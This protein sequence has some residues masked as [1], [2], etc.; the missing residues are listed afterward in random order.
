M[1]EIF[2]KYYYID[3]DEMIEQCRPDYPTTKE[4]KVRPKKTKGR[5]ND[6][7]DDDDDNGL[8]LNIFKFETFK[9][10]VERIFSEYE[11][12]DEKLGGLSENSISF[13]I[14]FNTLIR[15]NLLKDDE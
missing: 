15:Y 13:K 2:G 14:A 3:V 5:Q 10:C 7:D 1:L 9:A 8:S 11:P 12:V 6:D 4:E